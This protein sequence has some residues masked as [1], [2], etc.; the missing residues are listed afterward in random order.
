LFLHRTCLPAC[1]IGPP[2]ARPTSAFSSF[3]FPRLLHYLKQMRVPPKFSVIINPFPLRDAVSFS[4]IPIV[5]SI[6]FP[7]ELWS[8]AR[9]QRDESHFRSALT[10]RFSFF[11]RPFFSLFHIILS[12]LSVWKHPP[13]RRCYVQPTFSPASFPDLFS[14]DWV[15]GQILPF[16]L[17]Q[18][19]PSPIPNSLPIHFPFTAPSNKKSCFPT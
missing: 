16:P 11:F 17:A 10:P 1:V 13:R 18:L 14:T 15:Q 19:S 7:R 6:F 5:F 2:K 3:L 8:N 12:V 4:E 9:F